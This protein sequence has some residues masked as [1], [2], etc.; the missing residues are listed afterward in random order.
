MKNWR[1]WIL[2]DKDGNVLAKGRKK[3]V[4]DLAYAR[5]VYNHIFTDN[6]YQTKELLYK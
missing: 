5:Y 2:T 4:T 3:D 1:V 6:L